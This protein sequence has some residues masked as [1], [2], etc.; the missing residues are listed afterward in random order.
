MWN[1]CRGIT[2]AIANIAVIAQAPVVCI[3]IH[4][5]VKR[6]IRFNF[7][8]HCGSERIVWIVDRG[9]K[10]HILGIQI[11]ANSKVA[12]KCCRGGFGGDV[13]GFNGNSR[14]FPNFSG[15]ATLLY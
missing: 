9:G 2:V 10:I 4:R 3:Q 6:I 15:A 5:C 1:G 11:T 12:V 8:D 14:C 7:G 13:T